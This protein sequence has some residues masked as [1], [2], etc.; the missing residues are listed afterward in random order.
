MI[1]KPDLICAWPTH[2][3]YPLFREYIQT[4]RSK[5]H[6]IVISFTD[7]QTALPNYQSFIEEQL[8][9][10]KVS[11]VQPLPIISG[12]DWRNEAVKKALEI[13]TGD[14]VWFVEQDFF[15]AEGFWP[16]VYGLAQRTEAFGYYQE[17]RL[18][19]C[20][21]FVKRELLDKTSKDFSAY[22][23]KGY[24]H[25]GKLQ[26]DL[27]LRT[28]PGVLH[29]WTGKHLNGLSQ[30][31][32]LLQTGQEPNYNPEEFKEYCKKCLEHKLPEELAKLFKDY[33]EAIPT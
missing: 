21:I 25:F 31:I 22:P 11:F 5:L 7:M 13:A 24:D 18:H 10:D 17:D 29:Q 15:P 16:E 3:D 20:C 27:E 33:V 8:K 26:H 32:Y 1:I 28:N 6:Q 9:A 2:V 12:K 4:T 23:D 19:P 30:N 14:W